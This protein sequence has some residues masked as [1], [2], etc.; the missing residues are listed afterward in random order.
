MNARRTVAAAL[1][2]VILP[3]CGAGGDQAA[4]PTPGVTV[5]VTPPPPAATPVTTTP[6]ATPPPT[7]TASPAQEGGSS[8]TVGEGG[9]T[10][11]GPDGTITIDIGR[12]VTELGGTATDEGIDV[13]LSADVLFDF[14]SATLRADATPVLDRLA[15]IVTAYPDAPVRIS[16]HTDAIGDDASNQVLSEQR[17]AAVRDV[18]VQAHGVDPVR[19]TVQGFGEGQAV[20]PNARPDGSDD[21][22]GRARNRRVEVLVVGAR[23]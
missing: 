19:L 17:A 5:T 20:A 3:A 9:V 15:Q 10:V 2:G 8:I 12:V 22:E 18:L 4:A 16:G 7:A 1:L 23:P 14:G 6:P 11:T 13:P 21:P